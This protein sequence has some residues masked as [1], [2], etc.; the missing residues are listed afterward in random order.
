MVVWRARSLEAVGCRCVAC[1]Q[2]HIHVYVTFT[3]HLHRYGDS[4]SLKKK[5]RDRERESRSHFGSSRDPLG[6]RPEPKMVT[7]GSTRFR[8]LCKDAVSMER[9]L[10]LPLAALLPL[11]TLV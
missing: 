11:R 10:S 7:V 2:F 1:A 5:M 9:E 3:A 8:S 6:S 4:F